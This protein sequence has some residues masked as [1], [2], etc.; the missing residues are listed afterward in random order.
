LACGLAPAT[1]LNGALAG[2]AI[3]AVALTSIPAVW[4]RQADGVSGRRVAFR[5]LISTS[6]MGVI[7]VA[8]FV[9]VNP[10]FYARP[11]LPEATKVSDQAVVVVG[12]R[13][14]TQDMFEVM[15]TINGLGFLGRV[16]YL[17]QHRAAVLADGPVKF[18]HLAIPTR[19]Q[20][21]QTI[22][23]DG[24]GRWSALR[25][26]DGKPPEFDKSAETRDA[27]HAAS[28]AAAVVGI[29]LVPLGML[30]ALL[31]GKRQLRDGGVP[32]AW[33]LVA[34][35][36]IEVLT[37]LGNLTVG[38]D[39]YYMGVVTWTSLLVPYSIV[40]GWRLVLDRMILKPPASEA[41]A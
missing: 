20:R 13:R 10:Y 4:R 1:K 7:A 2:L 6:A 22:A 5:L 12:D 15:Q 17:M 11:Q 3:A 33:L 41:V 26:L 34:W 14:Y 29:C 40:Q 23:N 18:P 27:D 21:L 9:A 16:W 24:F 30:V 38:F 39:R 32:V 28:S 19:T 36:I 35:P 37:L 25:W 8:L 31:H